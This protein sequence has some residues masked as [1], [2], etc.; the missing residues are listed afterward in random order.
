MLGDGRVILHLVGGRQV[1]LYWGSGSGD[2]GV[3]H[4]RTGTAWSRVVVGLLMAGLSSRSSSSAAA[5]A[6]TGSVGFEVGISRLACGR[7]A[8]VCQTRSFVGRRHALSL[9]TGARYRT[10]VIEREP[11]AVTRGREN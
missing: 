7:W 2:E 6:L 5:L 10:V 8:D 1:P 4:V 3:L 11:V 9:S